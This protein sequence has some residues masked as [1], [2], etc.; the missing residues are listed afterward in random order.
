MGLV[1]LLIYSIFFTDVPIGHDAS[2]LSHAYDLLFAYQR[3]FFAL[4]LTLRSPKFDHIMK[5]KKR[6][7]TV[8]ENHA[9]ATFDHFAEIRTMWS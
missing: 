9:V 2:Y 8:V 5:R 4:S 7:T 1:L 6:I 3:L